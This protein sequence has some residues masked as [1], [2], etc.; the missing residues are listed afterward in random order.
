MK[1]TIKLIF[2]SFIIILISLSCKKEEENQPPNCSITN[3]TENAEFEIGDTINIYVEADD[4][5]GHIAE[6]RFYIDSVGVHSALFPYVYD[7]Y[8]TGETT[9]NHK[10]VVTAIDNLGSSTTDE[11]TIKIIGKATV[12]TNE[13]TNITDSSA[14]CGG[15]ITDDGGLTI[16]T[17]GVCWATSTNP[18]LSD[19]YTVDGSGMGVFT[20]AITGL[21]PF[22]EY[23]I[24]AYATNSTGT[25]YGDQYVFRTN[26][27][28]SSITDYDGN[29]S[30]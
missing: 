2:I 13:L 12:I 11:C 4:S 15:N 29:I 23:Y 20:S 9:G 28:N 18:T 22:T 19:N 30:V 21:G 14:T 8:T 10:I 26:W 5:D 3:P 1:N 24:R 17:R 27:D 6:V 16:I 7:W 25:S